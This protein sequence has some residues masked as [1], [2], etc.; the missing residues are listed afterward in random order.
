MHYLSFIKKTFSSILLTI[1]ILS[2]FNYTIDPFYQYR[3]NGFHP[4]CFNYA[5][6][7][8]PGF[9][10]N[11][12]YN[13][14]IIGTSMIENFRIKQVKSLFN[15]ESTLKIPLEAGKIRAISFMLSSVFQY[16][17]NVK[18][19]LWGLDTF[20]FFKKDQNLNDIPLFLFQDTLLSHAQYLLSKD[21]LII[22]FKLLRNKHLYPTWKYDSQQ[23]YEWQKEFNDQFL[24][25]NVKYDWEHREGHFNKYTNDDLKFNILK[26]NFD[27][28]VLP[29]LKAQK[30]TKFTL[31]FLPYSILYFKTLEEREALEDTLKL[32][33]YIFETTKSLPNVELYDFQVAKDITHNL[34][35]YKDLGH[36]HQKI[37]DWMIDQ[38]AKD[39]F[40]LTEKNIDLAINSLKK[41]TINYKVDFN[42]SNF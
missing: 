23:M 40:R 33:K 28:Y 27:T 2:L 41:Q 5:R 25:K 11:Y 18:N 26:K 15:N 31:V 29:I 38:M 32:K 21:T 8:N 34:H 12:P 14:L 20:S 1:I 16:K 4:T 39:H 3:V 9:I 35:N 6:K 36:Y 17:Q 19:V 22:S 37:N 24:I 7:N 13:S 30:R 42:T 10:K